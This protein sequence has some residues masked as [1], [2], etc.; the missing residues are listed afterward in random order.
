MKET[1]IKVLKKALE[2]KGVKLKKEEIEKLLEIPPSIEMG[3]YS[4]PC[5]FLV[6]KLKQEPGQIALEIRE[7][8]GNP[9]VMEFEDIQTS[10]AYIN[11]FLN[12][13]D[14]ARKIVWEVLTQKA[15]FGKIN[16]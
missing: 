12:R 10:G 1:V 2:E 14:F 8:I 6:E 7:K 13:K 9:P 11:F 5:F 3:D 16:L 4:F 15:K